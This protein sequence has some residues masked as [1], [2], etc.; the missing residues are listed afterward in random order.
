V[1]VYVVGAKVGANDDGAN[2]GANDDGAN[3]GAVGFAV[4]LHVNVGVPVGRLDG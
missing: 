3:V 2:V 1:Q 4:G